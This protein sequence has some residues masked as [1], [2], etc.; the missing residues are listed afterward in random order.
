M[1]VFINERMLL[2]GNDWFPTEHPQLYHSVDNFLKLI[3]II[4]FLPDIDLYY[5]EEGFKNLVNNI[6][7]IEG[8]TEY[9][10][11]AIGRM[12]QVLYD[13]GAYSWNESPSQ[14]DDYT[15]YLQTGRGSGL[16][17][18]INGST[19]AECSEHKFRNELT[20]LLSLQDSEYNIDCPIFINRS[21]NYGELEMNIIS[22]DN[23]FTPK[24]IVNYVVMNR[25]K[26]NFNLSKKHGE[27]GIG[28]LP[29]GK[30]PVSPLECSEAEA[31][32]LLT[33]AI[34]TRDCEELYA[35]DEIRE[36]F[37]VFKYEGENPQ[38]QYHGYHPIAQNDV[39]D[40]V[41]EFWLEEYYKLVD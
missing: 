18:Y 28:F 17:L 35:Y 29:N 16:P 21:K 24:A 9:T 33:K 36:K 14:K 30:G 11:G 15:Y 7:I 26:R 32:D 39:P 34:G 3:D 22:V 12:R 31:Q 4:N 20:A 8:E 19:V 37:I 25:E 41:K 13:I 27:K 38:N 23:L 2:D 6:T 1:K 10:M 5:S 40:R